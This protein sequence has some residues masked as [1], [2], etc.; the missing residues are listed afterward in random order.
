MDKK[1]KGTLA[2]LRVAA[3]LLANGWNVL[4]PYGENNRYDLVAERSGK[5]IR[6]QVKYVSPSN[7]GLNINCA[8]SN[9][10]SIKTYQ[11]EEI[12]YMAVYDSNSEKVYYI[13][14]SAIN[15]YKFKLRLNGSK[16]NQ[17]KGVHFAEHFT[18]LTV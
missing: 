5:F 1:Q 6:I 4:I 10:W 18:S 16:N 12:D 9:N 3:C 8:S 14:V 17:E 13:P 11:P 2:E 7:N 15:K